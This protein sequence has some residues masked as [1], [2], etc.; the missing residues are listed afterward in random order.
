[1][2]SLSRKWKILVI[3][4]LDVDDKNSE[5]FANNKIYRTM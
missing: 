5:K 1:M 3:N 2:D 4:Q